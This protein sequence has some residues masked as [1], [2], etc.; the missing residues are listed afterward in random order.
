MKRI[1]QG[2]RS[3]GSGRRYFSLEAVCETL[4]FSPRILRLYERRGLVRVEWI[5][6]FEGGRR[7]FFSTA[8]LQR[9]RRIRLLTD[10]M[11]VNLAGVEVILRLLERL[12]SR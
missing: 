7:A 9:L 10:E 11:G 12:E 8:E 1:I 6:T 5:K 3:S 4:D 2:R